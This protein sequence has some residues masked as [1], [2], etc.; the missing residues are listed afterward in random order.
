MRKTKQK[1][2]VWLFSLAVLVSAVGCGGENTES[3]KE[4]KTETEVTTQATTEAATAAPETTTIPATTV[5]V[6]TVP[7]TTAAETE[8]EASTEPKEGE[9]KKDSNQEE[10]ALRTVEEFIDQYNSNVELLKSSV[11]IKTVSV[12]SMDSEGNVSLGNG[13]EISFNPNKESTKDSKVKIANFQCLDK[14]KADID[15]LTG[16]A[17]CFLYTVDPDLSQKEL[18]S[19][20]SGNVSSD[21]IRGVVYKNY[22]MS[23]IILIQANF[24]ED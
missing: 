7:A 24:E 17:I 5:P 6:T 15:K 11:K 23:G 3:T 4:A 2:L 14:S 1:I 18:E 8:T 19:I 9:D 21:P 20:V 22:S 10:S 12:K 13:C 16:Q